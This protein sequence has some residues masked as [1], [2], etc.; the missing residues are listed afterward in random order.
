MKR[1]CKK[2]VKGVISGVPIWQSRVNNE[3]REVIHNGVYQYGRA[4]ASKAERMDA[5]IWQG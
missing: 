4:G 2:E 5:P 3:V 1:G